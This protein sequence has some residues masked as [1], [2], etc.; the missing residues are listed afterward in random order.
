M[1]GGQGGAALGGA[2]G[3]AF[4]WLIAARGLRVCRGEGGWCLVLFVLVLTRAG[5][6]G[7]ALRLLEC[8][9]GWATW[10]SARFLR[11]ESEQARWR[12]RGSG[13]GKKNTK[14]AYPDSR[15]VVGGWWVLVSIY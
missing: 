13:R 11:S 15:S 12:L 8:W 6:C 3:G 4:C 9:A 5:S 10:A 7:E 1:G 14:D 2:R